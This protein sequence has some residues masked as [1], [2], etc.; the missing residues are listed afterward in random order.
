MF[1]QDKIETISA[2]NRH[3]DE[4]KKKAFI[5]TKFKILQNKKAMAQLSSHD[6]LLLSD[7]LESETGYSTKRMKDKLRSYAMLRA[8]KIIKGEIAA[9]EEFA[10]LTGRY[11]NNQQKN[12][13]STHFAPK[14]KKVSEPV[15]TPVA[16][17]HKKKTKPDEEK[18]TKKSWFSRALKV[19]KKAV[20]VAGIAVISVVGGKALFNSSN[21]NV[22]EKIPEKDKKE[23]TFTPK[24]VMVTPVEEQ[25]ITETQQDSVSP[26]FQKVLDNLN[27]AYKDRFDSALEIHLGA[28]KRDQ[29]YQQID[30][31]AK[32]GR[33]EYKDGTTREWYAHAFTMYAKVAPNSDGGKLIAN[34]LA[35]KNVDK[36]AINDLV[37]NAK[38]DGTGISGT[39]TYSAFDKASKN[40]KKKHIQNRQNVRSLEKLVQKSR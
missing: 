12:F 23:T 38:R 29:L 34:L 33:I 14:P 17:P 1:E 39:G 16:T 8:E 4:E 37:I 31:L 10:E 36:T 24:K 3:K 6:M 7:A 9:D 32:D 28:E 35:G 22:S 18:K 26:E 5:A 2:I 20:I 25:Q 11:G 19:A 30:N 13:V 27:K 21:N 15:D 40:L